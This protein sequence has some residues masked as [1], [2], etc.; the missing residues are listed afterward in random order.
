MVAYIKKINFVPQKELKTVIGLNNNDEFCFK[1]FS[2]NAYSY[3]IDESQ[4]EIRRQV[5]ILKELKRSDNIIRFF[6]V[7][8]EDSKYYLVTEWIEHGNL[9]EYYTRFRNNINWD[10][11][12][13]MALDVCRGIAY[14]H[15]RKVS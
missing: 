15:G 4:F 13:K 6:G 9:Y 14:L 5:N 12:F 10:I 2:N 8:L 11:K 7:A 3:P 1:E